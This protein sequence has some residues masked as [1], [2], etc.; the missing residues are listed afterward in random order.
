MK[1]QN[2]VLSFYRQLLAMRHKEQAL[3]EGDY[4]A[5]NENDR[6]C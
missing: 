6:M 3:L 1:D 4:L 5:L 2:S